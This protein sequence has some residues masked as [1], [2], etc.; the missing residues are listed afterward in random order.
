LIGVSVAGVCRVVDRDVVSTGR[1][2]KR[3]I[4]PTVPPFV[5]RRMRYFEA[6]LR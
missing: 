3:R 1:V 4:F 5:V 6:S 2:K